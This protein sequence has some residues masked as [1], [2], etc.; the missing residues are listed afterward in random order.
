MYDRQLLARLHGSRRPYDM[1]L[2]HGSERRLLGRL[3]GPPTMDRG[4]RAR[5]TCANGMRPCAFH[6]TALVN[7]SGRNVLDRAATI[8]CSSQHQNIALRR[9]RSSA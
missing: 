8:S 9:D 6:E 1:Q 2:Q 7:G 3:L 4:G 5:A